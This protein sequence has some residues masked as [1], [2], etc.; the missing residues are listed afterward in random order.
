MWW[1]L[2]EGIFLPEDLREIIRTEIQSSWD[3]QGMFVDEKYHRRLTFTLRESIRKP[4]CLPDDWVASNRLGAKS[5]GGSS[6]ASSRCYSAFPFLVLTSFHPLQM[7]RARM[8]LSNALEYDWYHPRIRFV[9]VPRADLVILGGFEAKSKDLV[10]KAA[11]NAGLLLPT[12]ASSIY[13]PVHE[14]QI[15]NIKQKFRDIE[16]LPAEVSLPALAQSSIRSGYQFIPFS[17]NTKRR[18]QQNCHCSRFSRD[19]T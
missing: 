14:L 9:R 8:I 11:Q 2:A 16:V 17:N 19:S 12:G 1:K 3:W 7:H 4:T 13:M 5:G 18:S 15:E 10:A 6:N